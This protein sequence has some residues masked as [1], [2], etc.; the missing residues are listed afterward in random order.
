MDCW[1][2][3]GRLEDSFS[4]PMCMLPVSADTEK[5]ETDVSASSLIQERSIF[6]ISWTKVEIQK[7]VPSYLSS[8]FISANN[9]S[10]CVSCK[11]TF[12]KTNKVPTKL[13]HYF[14]FNR[15][16]CKEKGIK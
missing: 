6:Q 8:N 16:G 3:K 7:N 14:G 13:Q 12:P 1:L 5:A 2:K 9:L 10:Y 15:S 11:K 4:Q